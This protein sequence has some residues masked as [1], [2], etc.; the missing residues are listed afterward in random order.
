[1]FLSFFL[2]LFLFHVFLVS[3][4]PSF[5][6]LFSFLL[7]FWIFLFIPYLFLIYLILI[8]S[9]N[10][11]ILHILKLLSSTHKQLV[12]IKEIHT[13]IYNPK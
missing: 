6:F 7:F 12:I 4:F 11:N 9:F 3:H 10:P 2:L 1:V 5:T 8:F 13:Y